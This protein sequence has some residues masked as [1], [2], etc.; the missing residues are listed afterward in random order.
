MAY[1]GCKI[2]IVA[3]LIAACV[4]VL[5][6]LYQNIWLYNCWGLSLPVQ[7]TVT[8]FLAALV[9][10]VHAWMHGCTQAQAMHAK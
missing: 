10:G 3:L 6:V 7:V 1:T 4:F 9:I 2:V 5:T 8:V